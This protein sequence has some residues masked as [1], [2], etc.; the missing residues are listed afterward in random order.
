MGKHRTIVKAMDIS[1][2]GSTLSEI[3]KEWSYCVRASLMDLVEFQNTGCMPNP[4]ENLNFK[5]PSEFLKNLEKIQTILEGYMNSFYHCSSALERSQ[6]GVY[7][8]IVAGLQM[9]AY[10]CQKKTKAYMLAIAS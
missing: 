3:L 10:Q 2:N 6:Y 9:D 4:E 7:P 1:F 8:A 5:N